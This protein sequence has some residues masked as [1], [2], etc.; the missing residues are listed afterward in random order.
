M[1][2]LCLS[3]RAAYPPKEEVPIINVDTIWEFHVWDVCYVMDWHYTLE[4]DQE[5]DNKNHPANIHWDRTLVRLEDFISEFNEKVQ[6]YVALK[7]PKR[8]DCVHIVN[9]ELLKDKTYSLNQRL[10]LQFEGPLICLRQRLT[11][12]LPDLITPTAYSIHLGW[13]DE[14]TLVKIDANQM[15][16]R[17]LVTDCLPIKDYEVI[18]WRSSREPHPSIPGKHYVPIQFRGTREGYQGH[19]YDCE[20]DKEVVTESVPMK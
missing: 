10:T 6:G 16:V 17:D 3:A 14:D 19:E 15:V 5:Y 2:L 1:S 20:P 13:D 11:K 8:D 9:S 7:H 4:L 18:L 12:R